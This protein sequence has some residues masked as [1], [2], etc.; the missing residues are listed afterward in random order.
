MILDDNMLSVRSKLLLS[1]I[2]RATLVHSTP[3]L[4]F[5]INSQVPPVARIGEPFSF[6]FSDTTFT[7]SN[8]ASLSYSLTNPPSWLSL[9]SASRKFSGTR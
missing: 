8:G 1:A 2:F 7:S 4:S 5:P 6:V 3:T 9:D